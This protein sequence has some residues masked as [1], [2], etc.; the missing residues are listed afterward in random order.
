MFVNVRGYR[1]APAVH[2][3]RYAEWKVT[4]KRG[5]GFHR[6]ATIRFVLDADDRGR[7]YLQ[8]A[9]GVRYR[10]Y[11][12]RTRSCVCISLM[13]AM[14][15][16]REGQLTAWGIS[17]CARNVASSWGCRH[18]VKYARCRRD[19]IGRGE[20]Q[21]YACCYAHVYPWPRGLRVQDGHCA[22]ALAICRV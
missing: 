13:W 2:R 22:R 12:A 14:E 9:R 20:A 15:G 3:E 16:R 8:I 6:N 21:M 17:I 1:R 10:V 4:R 18:A 5:S 11:A 19:T 7:G